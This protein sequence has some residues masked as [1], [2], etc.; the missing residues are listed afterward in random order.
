LS[1]ELLKEWGESENS[2]IRQAP[3]YVISRTNIPSILIELGFLTNARDAER[4]TKA[5]FQK[6]IAQKIYRGLVSFRNSHEKTR[7]LAIIEKNQ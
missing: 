3:F 6:E 5:E 2:F 4:L 7:N 1:V